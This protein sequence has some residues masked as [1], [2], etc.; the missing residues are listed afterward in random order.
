MV[1]GPD[2]SYTLVDTGDGFFGALELLAA[3]FLEQIRLFQDLFRF[4][5]P[6]AYRFLS[7]VDI[8]TFNYRVFVRPW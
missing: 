1:R 4:H 2:A 5:I 8:V 6:N 7:S 3:G